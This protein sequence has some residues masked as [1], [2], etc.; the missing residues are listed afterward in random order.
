MSVCWTWLASEKARLRPV[1]ND[2]A[3]RLA[4]AGYLVLLSDLFDRYGDYEPLV[5]R[6]VFGGGAF[7]APN[8]SIVECHYQ[9]L[10]RAT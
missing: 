6:E 5:P 10:T 2:M 3:Q 8:L 7:K 9:C 1:V 4:D